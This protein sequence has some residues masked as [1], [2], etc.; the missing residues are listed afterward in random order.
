MTSKR[1]KVND[2][3]QDLENLLPND[4]RHMGDDV[5]KNLRVLIS[6]SL[7]R[8]NVITRDE[9][10]D[11]VRQLARVRDSMETLEERV[12]ALEKQQSAGTEPDQQ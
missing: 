10:D 6:S 12:A 2:L 8:V 7:A 1:D 11:Q 3:W 9:Y 4:L 5:K